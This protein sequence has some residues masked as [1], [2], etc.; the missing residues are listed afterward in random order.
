[1][2]SIDKPFLLSLQDDYTKYNTF[3]ET[4]TFIGETIFALESYFDKLYTIEF[5]YLYYSNAKN[6]Y[7]GNKI[8]FLLGDSSIVFT[9]LLPTIKD[10][11][12]FFLDGHWSSGNTGRS[13]KDCPL[14]EEITQIN[15]LFKNEAII[16]IDDVRLFG[17]SPKTGLNEDWSEINKEVLLDILKLRISKVYHLDSICAK[18]DRLIIHIN[19]II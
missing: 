16:I 14:I 2:P 6:R 3:I 5:A 11:S 4:G 1:M 7:N 17:K 18:D 9:T 12:I 19:A 10:K 15:L 8:N 13:A